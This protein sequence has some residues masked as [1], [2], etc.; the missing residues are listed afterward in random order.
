MHADLRTHRPID[1]AGSSTLVRIDPGLLVKSDPPYTRSCD[2]DPEDETYV[3]MGERYALS[4]IV[5]TPL[6]SEEGR[7]STRPSAGSRRFRSSRAEGE[8]DREPPRHTQ[9]DP[10]GVLDTVPKYIGLRGLTLAHGSA[11]SLWVQGCVIG[12]GAALGNPQTRKCL[13]SLF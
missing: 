11:L 3:K 9:F 1:A 2:S 4:P 8:H 12:A 7:P 5:P 6:R 13:E 10:T